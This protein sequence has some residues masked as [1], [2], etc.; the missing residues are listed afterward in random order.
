MI[1]QDWRRRFK[2]LADRL[3]STSVP[4]HEAEFALETFKTLNVIEES[5]PHISWNLDYTIK[6][7]PQMDMFDQAI[8]TG[9]W[10]DIL[11]NK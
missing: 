6:E 3:A 10:A 1:D 11:L 8:E 2:T 7:N 5:D 9:I 4:Y